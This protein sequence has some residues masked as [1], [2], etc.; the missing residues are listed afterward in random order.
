MLNLVQRYEKES[1]IQNKLV[2]FLF[3]SESI[4]EKAIQ[5]HPKKNKWHKK[6]NKK[7]AP[8]K[9]PLLLLSAMT[10]RVR[11]KLTSEYNEPA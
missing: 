9:K 6:K 11:I 1:G 5:I 4:L 2:Y 7:A 10:N 3:P 8:L